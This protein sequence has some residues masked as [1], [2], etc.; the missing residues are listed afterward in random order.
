MGTDWAIW[1]KANPGNIGQ[2]CPV[3]KILRSRYSEKQCGEE[4]LKKRGYYKNSNG[5]TYART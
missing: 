3:S 1:E 5:V 2:K 4:L